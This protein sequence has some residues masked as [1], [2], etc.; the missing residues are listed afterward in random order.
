MPGGILI[1][2][3]AELNLYGFWRAEGL[4]PELLKILERM[5]EGFAQWA[6]ARCG[7]G[8]GSSLLL[9][10]PGLE[11]VE[12]AFEEADGGDEVVVEGAASRETE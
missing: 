7:L 3:V 10:L 9:G 8:A 11:L 2:F 1:A 12:Q 4:F 6:I 5:G